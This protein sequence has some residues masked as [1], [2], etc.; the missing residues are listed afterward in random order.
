M[1]VLPVIDLLRG[2]VVRGIA[3]QRSEYR[4][5]R[6]NL[7]TS[8]QPLDVARAMRSIFGFTSLYLADLDAIVDRQP[9]WNCYQALLSDGFRLLVDA[10]VRDV[11]LSLE[12]RR[13][14]AEPIVGLES[15]PSPRVL[16]E[17]VTA[18]QGQVT[19]SVDLK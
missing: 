12:L 19:F 6:S 15:C 9:N 10:G 18:N 3:G 1:Q 2:V 7:T 11:P 13:I 8:V 16:A 5:L 14:G 4:P 17:I